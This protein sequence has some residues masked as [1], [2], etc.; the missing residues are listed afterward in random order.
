MVDRYH[1]NSKGNIVPNFDPSSSKSSYIKK[2]SSA[3]FGKKIK[4]MD[5]SG[6]EFK[7]NKDSVIKFLKTT[8][9]G[10]QLKKGFLG[11]NRSTD[12]QVEKVF[13]D[14]IDKLKENK[15]SLTEK[16]ET[17]KLDV[18]NPI[19]TRA[20][21]LSTREE[22]APKEPL[23]PSLSTRV[24]EQPKEP[25][26]NPQI[27][28][29]RSPDKEER[30]RYQKESKG[31][32]TFKNSEALISVRDKNAVYLKVIEL[33]K[34]LIVV[35]QLFTYPAVRVTDLSVLDLL[36]RAAN[37]YY[38]IQK[39]LSSPNFNS[40]LKQQYIEKILEKDIDGNPKL[41]TISETSLVETL[42]I[43]KNQINPLELVN[44]EGKNIFLYAAEQNDDTILKSLVQHFPEEAFSIKD[45]ILDGLLQKTNSKHLITTFLSFLVAYE[46]GASNEYFSLLLHVANQGRLK[47]SRLEQFEALAPDKKKKIYDLAYACTNPFIHEPMESPVL[48]NQYSVNFMWIN[49]SKISDSSERLFG[50]EHDFKDRFIDPITAWILANPGTRINIWYDEDLVSEEVIKR[51]REA[52][53]KAAGKSNCNLVTFKNIGELEVVQ[54]NPE[55]FYPEVPV[56][57]RADLLRSVVMDHVLKDPASQEQYA[58]Y[59]DLDVKAMNSKQ[60]FDKRTAS[61]LDQFGF[62]M[63]KGGYLK[64]ENSFQIFNKNNAQLVESHR[65]VIIDLTLE[66]FNTVRQYNSIDTIFRNRLGLGMG[67]QEIYDCYPAMLTHFLQETEHSDNKTFALEDFRHDRFK[68]KAH[69]NIPLGDGTKLMNET[70]PRKPVDVP[71]SHF[72]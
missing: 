41:F 10:A 35:R 47:D 34:E 29:I 51:V 63:T 50:D 27:L 46:Q 57:F 30:P 21:S 24:E 62:V 67:E 11:I 19:I 39:V 18:V 45:E 40:E 4:V 23:I 72:G 52:L 59:A 22:E 7:L 6:K 14:Y 42:A 64:F 58:V 8:E 9:D 5:A 71:P 31:T 26:I 44:K 55:V 49:K 43:L 68:L 17:T 1:I 16:L 15:E 56:Y 3:W 28:E 54:D 69:T 53:E 37:S 65:Q 32:D 20:P 61:F 12:S 38:S 2:G 66:K 70:M 36:L 60:L 13:T 25:L 33:D 48:P